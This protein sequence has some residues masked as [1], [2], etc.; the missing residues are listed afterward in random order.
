MSEYLLSGTPTFHTA[1]TISP[2]HTQV[3]ST[4]PLGFTLKT[5]LLIKHLFCFLTFGLQTVLL[6]FRQPALVFVF[7]AVVLGH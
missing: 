7:V 5:S 2:P 1:Q 6:S 3:N 4:A